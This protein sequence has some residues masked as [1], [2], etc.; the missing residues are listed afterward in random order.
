MWVIVRADWRSALLIVPSR[1]GHRLAPEGLPLVL[2]LVIK[3]AF[4]NKIRKLR[5]VRQTRRGF[6][7]CHRRNDSALSRCVHVPTH[8]PPSA[9]PACTGDYGSS[10]AVGSIQTKTTAAEATKQGSALLGGAESFVVWLGRVPDLG[11]T[12]HGGFLAPGRVSA[13]LALA[14]SALTA[15]KTT[16]RC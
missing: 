5:M 9:L 2:V 8:L 7:D 4:A 11:E 12:R 16:D 14:L 10:A 3:T 6:R 1:D 13:F 15:R